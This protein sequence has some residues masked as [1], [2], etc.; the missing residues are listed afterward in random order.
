MSWEQPCLD[1]ASSSASSS[2]NAKDQSNSTTM[3]ALHDCKHTDDSNGRSYSE[4]DSGF[5]DTSSDWKHTDATDQCNEKQQRET[6]EELLLNHN[7]PLNNSNRR[8]VIVAPATQQLSPFYIIKNIVQPQIVQKNAQLIW[9][10]GARPT[11]SGANPIILL[12]PPTPQLP[13][14]PGLC[15]NDIAAKKINAA[16]LP[17]KSYP[18]IAPHPNKK[19]PDK[20]TS[21]GDSF[22]QS[23]RVCI[24]SNNTQAIRNP[25]EQHLHKVVPST[26]LPFSSSATVSATQPTSSVS[27]IT[28]TGLNKHSVI[29]TRHRRFL[30]T[31]QV[32]KQSGLWDITLR[33][34]E[35]MR[36]SNATRRDI[37]QLR[38]HS[39]LLYQVANT[40]YQIPNTQTAAWFNLHKMMAESGSYPGLKDIQALQVPT[41]QQNVSVA[42]PPSVKG[43]CDGGGLLGVSDTGLT[44]S[45]TQQTRKSREDKSNE[46]PADKGATP[47]SSSDG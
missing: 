25:Q 28:T 19:P 24:E 38:Q 41:A 11:V 42:K 30:N 46:T 47:D 40:S 12:Q 1:V 6:K 7:G 39:D 2:K 44:Q 15:K 20:T 35:L 10:S 21:P 27:S 43:G 45:I 16:Y 34:K 37:A 18:R 3:Q 33:T 17:V 22:N 5:S 8:N 14:G 23:K 29:N 31:V 9:S 4:K 26:S 36:Q 13:K 32:L